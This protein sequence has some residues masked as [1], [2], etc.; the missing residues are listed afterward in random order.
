MKRIFYILAVALSILACTEEIDESNRYT[1]TGETVA[2]YMLHRSDKYSHFIKI[3]KQANL[4]SLLSTYGQYTLFLPDNDAVEKYLYEQDS[5]YWAARKENLTYDTGITSPYIEDLSDS[6]ANIIARTHLIEARYTL[7]EM[8]EGTLQRRNFNE[9]SLGINYATK[10]E[11]VYV[12]INNQSPIIT[13]DNFVENGVV[14]IMGKAINHTS[15]NLPDV[16]SEYHYFSLFYAAMK[17]TCFIENLLL[18]KDENYIPHDY[19]A[20]GYDDGVT[21]LTRQNL[22][23]KYFKYTAFIETDEVFKEN[24]IYTL[25]DLKAFAE[26]W[27]GTEDRNNPCSQKNALYKFV[28]YHFVERELAYNDIIFY[29][30]TYNNKVDHSMNVKSSEDVMIAGYDRYDYFETMHGPLMKVTK[31]LS[32]N[33]GADIFINYNKRELPY[34]KEMLDHLS[35]RIIPPIEFCNMREEYATFN[36]NTLNGIIN[37]IDKILIYNEDEMAGNI[38][39]ERMRFD[40]ATLLPELSCNKI[41]FYTPVNDY[42]YYIPTNYC[43]NLKFGIERPMLYLAGTTGYFA[44]CIG[45]VKEIDLSIKL[46][47]FPP[48]TYELRIQL[49]GVGVVQTYVD[50]KITGIPIKFNTTAE[51]TGYVPDAETDDNGLENDKQMRNLGWMKLP[52]TYK[53]YETT[54]RDVETIARKILTRKY[55]GPGEHWLR[56]KSVSDDISSLSIDYIELVP[57]NIINDPSK[58]EDRH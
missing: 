23:T 31:P 47:N 41:R 34:N 9:R 10:D 4:M 18:D 15:K 43:K 3:L 24:G 57:L 35:V 5:I 30:I 8:N 58:P 40:I 29:N 37:P 12:M 14:H 11:Q 39:N 46:P 44:D 16:I 51:H 17:E 36:H 25:D 52:D 54:A 1:F 42:L 32:T 20:M 6:M 53:L 55:F 27:Y 48:G 7:A 2:D 13:G 38:L 49:Y 56:I 26:K 21:T 50:N 22:E 45:T 33:Q 28:A 19:N